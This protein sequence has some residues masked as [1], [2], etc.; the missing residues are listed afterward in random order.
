MS[1]FCRRVLPH[2]VLTVCSV[3]AAFT[4]V[5]SL[6]AADAA[7]RPNILWLIAEDFGPHLGCYGTKEVTTPNLD[8]TGGRRRA[9]HAVLH[10]RARSAR[11]ADRRS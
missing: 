4:S 3:V 5:D 7:A 10:D 1:R 6:A 2:L 11:R 9:L 8:R